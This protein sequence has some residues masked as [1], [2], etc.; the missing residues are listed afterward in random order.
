MMVTSKR[1]ERAKT[2]SKPIPAQ[3]APAA[4]AARSVKYA[5]RPFSHEFHEKRMRIVANRVRPVCADAPGQ[6]KGSRARKGVRNL[7]QSKKIPEPMGLPKLEY[8]HNHP[9]ERGHVDDPVHGRYSSVRN[10]AGL[11]GLVE[12]V[13]DSV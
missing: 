3:R 4:G 12:V 5:D 2:E 11:P 6:E 10:E 13:T 9:V 1:E 7:F 8:L